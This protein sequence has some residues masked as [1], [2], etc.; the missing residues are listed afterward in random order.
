MELLG[1]TGVECDFV[2]GVPG[3]LFVDCSGT[4]GNGSGDLRPEVK[5]GVDFE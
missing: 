5:F 4:G 1:L 3:V 2:V